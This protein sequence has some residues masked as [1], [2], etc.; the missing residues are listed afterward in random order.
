MCMLRNIYSGSFFSLYINYC[1]H[2][3]LKSCD[4]IFMWSNLIRDIQYIF[5][6]LDLYIML[7]IIFTLYTLYTTTET[8][9]V[10]LYWLCALLCK[11]VAWYSHVL[12]IFRQ[13]AKS[14]LYLSKGNTRNYEW[15]EH[16]LVISVQISVAWNAWSFHLIRM[17]TKACKYYASHNYLSITTSTLLFP[18]NLLEKIYSCTDVIWNVQLCH[19]FILLYYVWKNVPVSRHLFLSHK[20]TGKPNK[21]NIKLKARIELYCEYWLLIQKNCIKNR[22]TCITFTVQYSKVNFNM[23]K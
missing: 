21:Y 10:F 23:N 22:E 4:A 1:Y 20:L 2:F 7:Y 8:P 17:R 9:F 3:R 16:W 12:F 15:Y 19:S 13:I 6:H 11:S 14:R 5:T 18:L